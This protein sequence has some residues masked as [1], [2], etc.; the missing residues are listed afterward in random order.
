[1]LKILY[2]DLPIE[3]HQTL[4]EIEKGKPFRY[5]KDDV[6][7][8]NREG[9]LPIQKPNYYREF[10]VETPNSTDRGARRIV[11]DENGKKFYTDDHYQNFKEIIE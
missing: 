2:G 9:K 6:I 7:F 5:A 11:V 1:M 3:A 4:K 10:T 8:R